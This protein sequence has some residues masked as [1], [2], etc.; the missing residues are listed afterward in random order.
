MKK[1]YKKRKSARQKYFFI[2]IGI[3]LL[4]MLFWY[5]ILGNINAVILY[6]ASVNMT[7]LLLYAWDKVNAIVNGRENALGYK[8]IAGKSLTRV[9]EIIL[10]GL[11]LFGG[12]PMAIVGQKV[13]RHKTRKAK[14]KAWQYGVIVVQVLVVGLYLYIQ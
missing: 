13:F 5:I 9:P 8:A 3:F 4:S 11:A 7:T 1:R 6:L 14:F 12:S 2:A 10:H